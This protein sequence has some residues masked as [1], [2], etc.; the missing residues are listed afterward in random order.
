MLEARKA[1]LIEI[2]RSKTETAA[3]IAQNRS[4]ADSALSRIN[5][6]VE[7]ERR[8]AAEDI[9]KARLASAEEVQKAR[10]NAA[11]ELIL[12][13]ERLEQAKLQ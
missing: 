8:K 3:I 6:S 2:E 13:K 4:K 11:R 7:E 10:E 1:S 9:Q 12:I 5:L